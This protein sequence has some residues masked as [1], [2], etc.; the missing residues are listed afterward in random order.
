LFKDERGFIWS[1]FLDELNELIDENL[2]FKHD[3]VSYSKKNVLRGIH[4][5]SKTWKLVTCVYGEIIQV[6]VDRRENSPTYN[7]WEKF[8]INFNEPKMI[9]IPPKMGNGFFVKSMEC[10]YFYKLAYEGNYAD[11]D[12]QF[13]IPWDDDTINIDWGNITPILSSRDKGLL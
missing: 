9:L 4:G 8:I 13:T 6:V 7:K 2:H 3:K 11:Y 10:I 12:E 5:D 1:S